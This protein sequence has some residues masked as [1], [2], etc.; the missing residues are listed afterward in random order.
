[1]STSD[2]WNGAKKFGA[3]VAASASRIR[4][5]KCEPAH[6]ALIASM[7]RGVDRSQHVTFAEYTNMLWCLRN[8]EGMGT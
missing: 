3:C 4:K 6:G 1:M 2:A 5:A 7:C 8:I